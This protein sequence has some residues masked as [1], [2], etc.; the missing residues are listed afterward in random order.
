M[1]AV[2]VLNMGIKVELVCNQDTHNAQQQ[3]DSLQSQVHG[4]LVLLV[5]IDSLVS[6]NTCTPKEV[7][8]ELRSFFNLKKYKITE[9]QTSKTQRRNNRSP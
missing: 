2:E 6:N 9:L 5:S 3:C 7:S 1:Q 4:L 8:L